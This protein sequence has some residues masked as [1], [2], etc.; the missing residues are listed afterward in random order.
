MWV[1]VKALV[2][3]LSWVLVLD[4]AVILVALLAQVLV[5]VQ[6]LGMAIAVYI[7]GIVRCL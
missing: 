3:S 7:L 5:L 1:D 4:L 2:L 6:A